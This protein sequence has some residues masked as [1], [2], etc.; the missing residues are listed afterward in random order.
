MNKVCISLLICVA[1]SILPTTYAS[2]E[3]TVVLHKAF[4]T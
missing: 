3:A 4:P 1:I 2:A